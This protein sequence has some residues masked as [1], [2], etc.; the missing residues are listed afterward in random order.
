RE[1]RANREDRR[2]AVKRLTRGARPTLRVLLAARPGP[3]VG[4]TSFDSA[5][6]AIDSLPAGLTPSDSVDKQWLLQKPQAE[7]HE[8]SALEADR[9]PSG[10]PENKAR[11]TG[12]AAV[13]TPVCSPSPAAD[14][15]LSLD[16]LA[17][18]LLVLSDGDRDRLAALLRLRHGEAARRERGMPTPTATAGPLPRRT[19]SRRLCAARLDAST[20][21]NAKWCPQRRT[22][23]RAQ[24]RR[25]R[26]VAALVVRRGVSLRRA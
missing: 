4:R 20:R 9:P 19:P 17:A 24:E 15:R 16:V 6:T 14:A 21:Q 25:R 23:G 12:G 26:S 1:A 11:S 8:L 22:A 5:K 7:G 13:C 2:P 3:R 10:T 18:A